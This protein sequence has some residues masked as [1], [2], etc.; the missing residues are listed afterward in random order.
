M[1]T[2]IILAVL[3]LVVGV[4]LVLFYKYQ[5][6]LKI[7]LYAHN[8]CLWCIDEEELDKDKKFDAFISYSHHDEEFALN[9][10]TELEN[11]NPRFKMCVH[12]RDW[13]A[14]QLT[15]E[16]VSSIFYSCFWD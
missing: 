3:S 11:G 14:G 6:L 10:V 15:A 5:Q 12:E 8:A 16:S 1:L 7:W 13:L 4:L 2:S 9:I